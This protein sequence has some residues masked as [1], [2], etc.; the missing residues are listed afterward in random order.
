M[1][2]TD[3]AHF[4]VPVASTRKKKLFCI[5]RCIHMR[6]TFAKNM[7][8]WWWM[9][10]EKPQQYQRIQQN[11]LC[12]MESSKSRAKFQRLHFQLFVKWNERFIVLRPNALLRV[13]RFHRLWPSWKL[14]ACLHKHQVE[15]ILFFSIMKMNRIVLSF[16]PPSRTWNFYLVV[17]IGI[18]TAR[19]RWHRRSSSRSIPF[20][21][22]FN[23]NH[24]QNP[25]LII[26]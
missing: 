14:M 12:R 21:V 6:P 16:S 10:F 19:F 7:Y 25:I 11:V 9:I 3:T 2:H 17:S 18:W 26:M 23:Q 8:D 5:T 20:M 15:T 1:V 22:I 24:N 13:E 4:V